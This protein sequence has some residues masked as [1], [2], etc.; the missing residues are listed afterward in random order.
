MPER[1]RKKARRYVG[2]PRRPSKVVVRPPTGYNRY[3]L[4][5]TLPPPGGVGC[6]RLTIQGR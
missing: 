3:K 6:L 2:I 1:K 4:V 5:S